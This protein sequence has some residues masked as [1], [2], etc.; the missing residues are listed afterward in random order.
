MGEPQIFFSN[1][2]VKSFVNRYH[3]R[4]EALFSGGARSFQFLIFENFKL[5]AGA[6]L[7]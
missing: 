1:F 5:G 3:R 2:L 6:R 7:V 4:R